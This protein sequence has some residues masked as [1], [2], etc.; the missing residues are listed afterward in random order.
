MVN[1]TRIVKMHLLMV[2]SIALLKLKLVV[3]VKL[4]TLVQ[5]LIF[6]LVVWKINSFQH[7]QL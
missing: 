4:N 1:V 6:L 7:M 2:K 5:R 3:M